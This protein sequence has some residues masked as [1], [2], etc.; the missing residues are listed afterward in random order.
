[1]Y[2]ITNYS[3]KKAKEHNVTIK[4]SQNKNKK[5]DVYKNGELIAS[6]GAIGYKDYPTYIKENGIEYANKR[7][8]LY[9]QRHKN[10]LTNKNSNGFWANKILW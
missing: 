3:Y 7:R 1:M 4:P 2:I 10:D 6:I 9:R 8:Q 5:I